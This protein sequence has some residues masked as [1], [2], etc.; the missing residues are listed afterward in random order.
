[1]P[2][3]PWGLWSQP[4]KHYTAYVQ[5]NI[6]RT[7]EPYSGTSPAGLTLVNSAGSLQ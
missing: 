2:D 3:I 6:S 4:D 5:L 1:M 7:Y